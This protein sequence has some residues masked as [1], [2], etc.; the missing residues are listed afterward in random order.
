MPRAGTAKIGVVSHSGGPHEHRPPAPQL[1]GLSFLIGKLSGEGWYADPS[2]RYTKRVS[3]AW[4]AG[5]HHLA[6]EM[7]TDYPLR[8]GL[9]DRHSA[10]LV[11]SAAA[12]ENSLVSRAYTDGGSVIEYRPTATGDGLVFD[13]RVPHGCDAQRA[14]KILRAM[15][16][17][18]DEILE[19]DRGDGA[20]APYSMIALRRDDA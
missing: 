13:D 11:I 1:A 17:G 5:G 19:I 10:L 4:V 16:D 8:D 20:F 6:L 15:P 7:S 2:Q 18:Y 12:D 3:G 14:R 9:C